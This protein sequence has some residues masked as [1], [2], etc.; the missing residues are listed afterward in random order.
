VVQGSVPGVEGRGGVLV[1]KPNLMQA[2]R[3]SSATDA[4]SL[5]RSIRGMVDFQGL[6]VGRGSSCHGSTRPIYS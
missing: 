6:M 5:E 4:S 1:K 2:D 3:T